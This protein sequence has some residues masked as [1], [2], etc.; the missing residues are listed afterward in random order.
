MRLAFKVDFDSEGCVSSSFFSFPRPLI[1]W[2]AE[3]EPVVAGFSRRISI[4][5][6]RSQDASAR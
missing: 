6:A 1:G 5:C 3:D 4:S 2:L